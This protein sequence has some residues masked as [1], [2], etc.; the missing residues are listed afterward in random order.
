[1]KKT[2]SAQAK[3]ARDPWDDGELGQSLENAVVAHME[4]EEI[5]DSLGLQ[6][7][8]IRLQKKLISTLKLIA[9]HHGIG[10]Q[11]MIRDLLNRFAA[12]EMQQ[13]LQAHMLEAER[14]AEAAGGDQG[15]VSEFLQRERRHA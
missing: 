5:D 3:N 12:S 14:Q 6:L 9:G 8:S 4:S 13:V 2:T 10:Y 1:M 7:V 11:P 15:P